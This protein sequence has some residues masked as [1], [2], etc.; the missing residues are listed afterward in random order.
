M[1][2]L[3][4]ITREKYSPSSSTSSRVSHGPAFSVS[5]RLTSHVAVC[6]C[7]FPSHFRNSHS[8]GDRSHQSKV[9][10]SFVRAGRYMKYPQA[11]EKSVRL[12]P[13]CWTASICF[14]IL[15]A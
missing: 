11:E 3:A 8:S 5:S 15:S 4:L 1:P 12:L 10:E 9:G 6:M 2:L 14:V 7:R 13:H